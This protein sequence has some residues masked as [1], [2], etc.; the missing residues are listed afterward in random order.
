[1]RHRRLKSWRDFYHVDIPRP[2]ISICMWWPDNITIV[3]NIVWF[4]HVTEA[5]MKTCSHLV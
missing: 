1:M 5:V 4:F 3:R 2:I